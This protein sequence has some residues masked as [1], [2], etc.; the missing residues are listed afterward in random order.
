[1]FRRITALIILMVSAVAAFAQFNTDRLIQIGRSALYYE[2]YVLSIQYFNQAINAKPYLYEPWYFRAI[3]KYYLDDFAGAEADCTEAMNRN[4][5][6]VGVYELRGL[7]RIQQ[8]KFAGAVE[9]YTKALRFAPDNQNL[10]HNRTLCRIQQKD[11]AAAHADLDTMLTKW[12]RYARG[13]AMRADVYVQQKDTA[14]AEKAL[15]KSCEID[16]YNTHTWTARSYIALG[17][18]KWKDADEYLSK[19]IHLNPKLPVNYI[20][21]ALARVNMNKLRGA[22]ADYDMALDVDP[23]NFLAHYNRG[24]LRAQV[25]DDNRAITDFDFVL[26]LEPDNIMAL[27]N[28]A[29]LLDNTGNLRGA[30]RDYSK[31]IDEFPNFWVGLQ[32]RARCYRRLGMTKQAEADEFRVY[33]AQLYKHLYGTQ[34]RL[35]KAQLRKRSDIDPD[36]Y[37]QLT[38]ADEQEV[39]T[40]YSNEYRGKVQNRK[41]AVEFL[42]MYELSFEEQKGDGVREHAAYSRT[43]DEFNRQNTAFKDLHIYIRCDGATLDEAKTRRYFNM[44]DT[45]SV[46]IQRAKT[47]KEAMPLLLCRAITYSVIQNFDG[48]VDDLYNYIQIDSTSSLAFWQRAVCQQ[49]MNRFDAS[50]GTDV[51]MK[52]ANVLSDLTEAIALDPSS[53]YLYYNR[54][55]VYVERIDYQHAV[56]DYNKAIELDPNLA[57]AYFNRGLALVRMKKAQEGI[58]DLSKAG[59]LGIYKAYSVIKTVQA[60]SNL[61]NK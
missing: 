17:Q 57:E 9:D 24:L 7:A 40:E 16:P 51:G 39:Q 29:L 53:P 11:Y 46:G 42:P 47:M 37:N 38:V 19:A 26:K 10:W 23:N 32:A 27:Y 25:G 56:A 21:R 49:K 43:V 55:N 50:Q 58:A 31:V 36:K 13:Y 1:M 59:E 5:Y 30:I 45:L 41:V 15:E 61:L 4:P 2:D 34:P 18:R 8:E 28:R 44:L 3:G 54:G 35:N 33:K 48:A 52:T 60:E 20:N 14:N 22:M 6:V 12:S